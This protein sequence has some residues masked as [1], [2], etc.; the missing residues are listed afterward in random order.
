MPGSRKR[1]ADAGS[2]A[3]D[4]AAAE[5]VDLE[6]R[7]LAVAEELRHVEQQIYDL[8]TKYLETSSPFGNAVRG[9]WGVDSGQNSS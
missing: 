4:K 1:G 9:T 2:P 5:V 3:K 8:E 6:K 7:R